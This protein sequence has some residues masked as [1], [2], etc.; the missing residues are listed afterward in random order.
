[1]A[2]ARNR[3]VVELL[4]DRGARAIGLF[5]AG[6][7][8][9]LATL[10]LLIARGAEIDECAEDETPFLHCWKNR[11]FR[12]AAVLLDAG[13]DIDFQDSKG[14]GALHH[15]L[16]RDF[17]PARLRWLLQRGADPER[18]DKTGTSARMKAQR[19]RDKR[20]VRMF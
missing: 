8:E 4:L 18:K 12:A 16:E 9:D 5:A 19:K 1:V 7:H 20:Y 17:E 6:W 11:R 3:G 10:R 15:A 13:A 14:R 2:H